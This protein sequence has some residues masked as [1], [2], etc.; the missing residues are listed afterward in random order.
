MLKRSLVLTS[1]H[2]HGDDVARAITLLNRGGY[3][4]GLNDH[5]FGPVV[6]ASC[7][8]AKRE[9]GYPDKECTPTYGQVLDNLLCGRTKPSAA[10]RV[11]AALRKRQA[12]SQAGKADRVH[13]LALSQVGT[14]ESPP[15]S[16]RTKYSIWYGIIGAWCAMFITW[17]VHYAVGGRFHYAYVPFVVADGL[18]G[19]GGLRRVPGPRSGHVIVACYDWNDDRTA[20]HIGFAIT[21]GDLRRL[22]MPHWSSAVTQWGTLQPGELWSIEGNTSPSDDSNGG[23]VWVRK[24]RYADV[25]AFVEIPA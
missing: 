23:E 13:V 1:P 16:N 25:Q 5:Q 4:A 6:A 12:K 15:G 19:Y 7:V 22:S 18:R 21:D 2:M 11:R 10:M 9:L 20:D 14:K 17:V 24:R 3:A 8:R